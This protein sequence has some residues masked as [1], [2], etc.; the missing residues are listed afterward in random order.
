MKEWHCR[1][2][3]GSFRGGGGGGEGRGEG[4]KGKGVLKT[5]V[6]G[7]QPCQNRIRQ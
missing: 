6:G 3:G 2:M 1:V 4:G 7:V 5:F